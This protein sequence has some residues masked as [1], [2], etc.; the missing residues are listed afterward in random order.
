MTG[1]DFIPALVPVVSTLDRLGVRY[2]VG[3]S[4]A[5]IVYGLI[6]S[7][8]DVDLVADL[9]PDHIAPFVAPLRNDYY[10]DARM[11]A[12][13]I[14]RKSCFNMIHTATGY[15]LDIF[16]MKRRDFDRVALSRVR[17]DRFVDEDPVS[18]FAVVSPED[19][20]LNKL[21]WFRLGDEVSERQWRDVITVLRAQRA[22]LDRAYLVQWARQ[23]GVADLLEKAWKEV[24]A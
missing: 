23:L 2:Y 16:A 12:E 7:T 5:G 4:V 19:L 8:A 10:V 24:E 6:R 1:F 13:A 14:A 9:T 20:L 15:K 3:G 18:E 17:R 11:I 21:E 22:V